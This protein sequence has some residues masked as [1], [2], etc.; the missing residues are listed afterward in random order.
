MERLRSIRKLGVA[1]ALD[2]FGTGFASMSYLQTYPYQKIKIDRSFV[3]NMADCG[4]SQSLP[5][6]PTM[7]FVSY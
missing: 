3:A 7:C 2:D 5:H 4:E 1:I 6:G